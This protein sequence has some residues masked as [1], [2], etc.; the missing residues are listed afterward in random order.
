MKVE[1]SDDEM[2]DPGLSSFASE[3]SFEEVTPGAVESKAGEDQ[4]ATLRDPEESSSDGG[5]SQDDAVA[6]I[7]N[8]EVTDDKSACAEAKPRPSWEPGYVMFKHVRTQV[9]H[10]CAQGSASGTF[11]C[12][13]K[14]TSDFKISHSKFLDF[15]RCKTCEGAKPL[16]DTGALAQAVSSLLQRKDAA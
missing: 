3:G 9:V 6:G 16:R 1:I 13:R 8:A 5:S 12:G 15:R 4:V 10:L 2:V 7:D 11:A 14:M